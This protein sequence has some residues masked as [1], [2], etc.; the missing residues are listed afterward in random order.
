MQTTALLK[1]EYLHE[2]GPEIFEFNFILQKNPE[3]PEEHVL[4]DFHSTT[5]KQY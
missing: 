3:G 2:R 4:G 1:Q 5:L